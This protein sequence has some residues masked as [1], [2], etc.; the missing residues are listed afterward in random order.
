MNRNL[1]AVIAAVICVV[2][3]IALGFWTIGSPG[4]ERKI[5]QDVR[6]VQGLAVL[7]NRIN[8]SWRASKLL[9]AKLDDFPVPANLKQ[10]PATHAPFVYRRKTTS[11]YE[12]C[13]TFLTDDRN[14]TAGGDAAFWL[15]SKGLYCFDLD[16]SVYVPQAPYSYPF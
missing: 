3:A 2:A 14:A 12:L 10:D 13:A 8:T 6:T 4:H 16:A 5:H 9:P 7:G 15:H 11:E 1:L